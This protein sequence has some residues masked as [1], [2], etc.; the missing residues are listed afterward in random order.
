MARPETGR[1]VPLNRGAAAIT[2]GRSI[3]GSDQID[4]RVDQAVQDG[5][6][7]VDQNVFGQPP[8]GQPAGR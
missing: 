3:P 5:A 7:W 1:A 8:A 2:T 6:D 4:D